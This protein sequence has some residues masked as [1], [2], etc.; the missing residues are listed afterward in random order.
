MNEDISNTNIHMNSRLSWDHYF[1]NIAY[2]VAIRSNCH[3][4]QIGALIVKDRRILSTGYNGS[5]EGTRDCLELGCLRD[6]LKI[7][8]GTKQEI[9]RAV[10]AEQNA[11]MQCARFGIGCE[12][13]TLYTTTSP[14]TICAKLI[15]NSGIKRIV[16]ASEYS[17]VE[18]V[19]IFA[20]KG[21]IYTYIM[22]IPQR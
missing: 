3:R 7:P 6:E 10:H 9:C 22:D 20:Q 16:Y 15:A 1:I 19:N 12:G 18:A 14:C 2:D 13:A 5:V 11:L 17:D 8:S 4:R 21:I